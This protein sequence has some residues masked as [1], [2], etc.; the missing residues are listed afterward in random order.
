MTA[1]RHRAEKIIRLAVWDQ[2]TGVAGL[3]T[4]T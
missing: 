1:A 3:P 2:I 4:T